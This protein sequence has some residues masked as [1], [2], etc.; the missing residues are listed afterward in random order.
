MKRHKTT[1]L[2]KGNEVSRGLLMSLPFRDVFC[3][4]VLKPYLWIA[5]LIDPYC[6]IESAVSG[7]LQ[8]SYLYFVC[9]LFAFDLHLIISSTYSKGMW[10]F[11]MLACFVQPTSDHTS[12][13]HVSHG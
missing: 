11:T 1:I 6:S 8:Q 9:T 3:C 13:V 5:Y 2:D 10:S 12:G 4:I 7:R